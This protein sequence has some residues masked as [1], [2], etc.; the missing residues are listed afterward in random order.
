MLSVRDSAMA[1]VERHTS[2]DGLLQLIVARADDGD[3]T[4]GFDRFAWHTHGDIL[5]WS[6]Y[7]GTPAERVRTFV[8]DVIA[9][10]R[11]IVISR[12]NGEVRD[13]WVTDDPSCDETKYT[14]PDETIEKRL[15]N[16]R[17]AAG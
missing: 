13:A 7:A 4:V 11:V 6:G 2:P 8:D 1:I 16:G 10:R 3:W 5:D 14:E 9:S 12:V 15:W 17:P